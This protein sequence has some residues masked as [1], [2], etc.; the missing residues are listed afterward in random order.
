[1]VHHAVA[2]AKNRDKMIVNAVPTGLA[3]TMGRWSSRGTGGRRRRL[4]VVFRP[5]FGRR[6]WSGRLCAIDRCNSA[7]RFGCSAVESLPTLRPTLRRWKRRTIRDALAGVRSNLREAL[8]LHPEW[9]ALLVTPCWAR[10]VVDT[11]AVEERSD[12]RAAAFTTSRRSCGLAP[13]YQGRSHAPRLGVLDSCG[14]RRLCR[15][16]ARE[17]LARR[18]KRLSTMLV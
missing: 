6:A 18:A 9:R 13:T 2:H 15:L 11:D 4:K 10:R 1:M 14:S 3:E 12:E 8:R 17:S 5:C 7:A 16:P